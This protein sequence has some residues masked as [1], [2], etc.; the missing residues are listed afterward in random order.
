MSSLLAT[1]IAG[2]LMILL[3]AAR[4]IGGALLLAHGHGADA[5]ISAS[6]LGVAAVAAGLLLVGVL[7][8]LCGV[9]VIRQPSAWWRLAMI[10]T[11]L[12]VAG[13]LVNGTILYG[14]PGAGGTSM[15]AAVAIVI[16]SLLL[17]TRR[18]PRE[19]RVDSMR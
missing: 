13:G 2:A 19:S 4:G 17:W 6:P 1:R 12:F 9:G 15:N 3:G 18:G 11:T 16:M 7:E 10:A 8:I 5:S 14:H